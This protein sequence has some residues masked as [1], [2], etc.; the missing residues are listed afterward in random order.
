MND[1]STLIFKVRREIADIPEDYIDDIQV[2]Q[3]IDEASAFLNKVIDTTDTS[4]EDSYKEHCITILASY[5]A[6]LNYTS[7]AE[8]RIGQLP[9]SMGIKVNE[10]KKK[11]H[12]F[13]SKISDSTLDSNFNV[14]ESSETPTVIGLTTSIGDITL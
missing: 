13:I 2:Y 12:A 4:I 10:M 3:C 1:L 8:K 5:Y 6:Y 9:T 14:K 11:A 7:L